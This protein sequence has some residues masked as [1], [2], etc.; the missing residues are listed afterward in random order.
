M[1]RRKPNPLLKLARIIPKEIDLF[2]AKYDKSNDKEQVLAEL[3]DLMKLRRTNLAL[4]ASITNALGLNQQVEEEVEV[5]IRLHHARQDG[6]DYTT[7]DDR[8][9][10]LVLFLIQYYVDVSKMMVFICSNVRVLFSV[11]IIKNFW[12]RIK[13]QLKT[14]LLMNSDT[15]TTLTTLKIVQIIITWHASKS[16][17]V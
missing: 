12:L 4:Y 9:H 11:F 1:P 16:R 13:M 2:A 7:D 10:A 6:N 14:K 8:T 17:S 15:R 3:G 5:H